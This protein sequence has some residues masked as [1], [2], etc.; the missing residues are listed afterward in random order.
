MVGVP[1]SEGMDGDKQRLARPGVCRFL[2]CSARCSAIAVQVQTQTVAAGAAA[3]VEVSRGSG[4][5][6]EFVP[7]GCEQCR[8]GHKLPCTDYRRSGTA[9]GRN[10][11]DGAETRLENMSRIVALNPWLAVVYCVLA[12][13]VARLVDPV[14]CRLDMLL[15]RLSAQRGP[16]GGGGRGCPSGW[17]AERVGPSVAC[18][19]TAGVEERGRVSGERSCSEEPTFDALQRISKLFAVPIR[20]VACRA[21]A[22]LVTPGVNDSMR[23]CSAVVSPPGWVER[24]RSAP[25]RVPSCP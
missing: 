19:E 5:I 13:L 12:W 17:V 22:S 9:L 6:W 14:F 8:G 2:T 3:L 7:G 23:S 21:R 20:T 4:T 1:L 11:S 25:R 10:G 15:V 24:G 18:L 16:V